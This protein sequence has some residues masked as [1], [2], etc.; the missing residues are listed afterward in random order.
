MS[1]EMPGAAAG[2]DGWEDAG[3]CPTAAAAEASAART[4]QS[5]ANTYPR[6]YSSVYLTPT[7]AHACSMAR[8]AALSAPYRS[9]AD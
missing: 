1:K 7:A 6:M 4:V 8:T 2:D 9:C 3:C 5:V